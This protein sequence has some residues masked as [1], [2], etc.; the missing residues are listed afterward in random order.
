VPKLD[1][2][3]G[4]STLP[5]VFIPKEPAQR[6]LHAWYTAPFD[7]DFDTAIATPDARHGSD[8]TA[9]NIAF[10]AFFEQLVTRFAYEDALLIDIDGNVVYSAYDGADLGTNLD[11]GPFKDTA[12]TLLA[13]DRPVLR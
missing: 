10:N 11:T 2:N 3:F 5:D 1:A 9:A 13:V 4:T 12:L 8:W 6:Y 7:D